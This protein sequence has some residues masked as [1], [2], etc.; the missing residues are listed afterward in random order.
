VATRASANAWVGRRKKSSAN[1]RWPWRRASAEP[2]WS[3]KP[4]QANSFFVVPVR[5]GTD[6]PWPARTASRNWLATT[7]PSMTGPHGGISGVPAAS[8]SATTASCA[9]ISSSGVRDARPAR[10]AWTPA[11]FARASVM[12]RA[13]SAGQAEA[14]AIPLAMTACRNRPSAAAE[15]SREATAIPPADWPITVT[16]PGSPPNAATLSRTHSS[17]AMQSSGRPRRSRL[18]CPSRRGRR[19]RESR[20]GP[21]RGRRGPGSRR[22]G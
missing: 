10:V 13:W 14:G 9:S 8:Y 4:R 17:A 1:C 7:S 15:T 21:G 3:R 2:G 22:S 20:P 19:R 18:R 6:E 5:T 11:R 16:R 12:A